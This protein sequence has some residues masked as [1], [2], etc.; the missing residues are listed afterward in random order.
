MSQY[1]I[2]GIKNT[3]INYLE[4]LNSVRFQPGGNDI[5][6]KRPQIDP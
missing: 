5:H 3:V 2:N 4:Y 1:V 6:L